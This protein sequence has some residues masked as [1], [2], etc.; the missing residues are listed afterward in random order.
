MSS[1][2]PRRFVTG[3]AD[4]LDEAQRRHQERCEMSQTPRRER[5]A[6]F[7]LDQYEADDERQHRKEVLQSQPV[8]HFGSHVVIAVDE[9]SYGP[10]KELLCEMLKGLFVDHE[11]ANLARDAAEERFTAH[12]GM[13]TPLKSVFEFRN[14]CKEKLNVETFAAC[15]SSLTKNIRIVTHQ[16]LSIQHRPLEPEDEKEDPDLN[17]KIGQIHTLL[18][19]GPSS[20]P[21]IEKF[22]KN[23]D[24]GGNDFLKAHH[25][26]LVVH[27]YLSPDAVFHPLGNFQRNLLTLAKAD[28]MFLDLIR[29]G[30]LLAVQIPLVP[31]NK[32]ATE[33]KTVLDSEEISDLF[34]RFT[35]AGIDTCFPQDPI[36]RRER[37]DP[38]ADEVNFPERF[39]ACLYVTQFPLVWKEWKR[40]QTAAKSSKADHRDDAERFR[41]MLKTLSAKVQKRQGKLVPTPP[42]FLEALQRNTGLFSLSVLFHKSCV[43][44]TY[45]DPLHV[46]DH[47]NFLEV[48]CACSNV[49]D[50]SVSAGIPPS[51]AIDSVLFV[52][53]RS[54]CISILDSP[55]RGNK[56][57][58]GTTETRRDT[59][60]AALYEEGRSI[61]SKRGYTHP[62]IVLLGDCPTGLAYTAETEKESSFTPLLHALGFVPK[63]LFNEYLEEEKKQQIRQAIKERYFDFTQNEDIRRKFLVVDQVARSYSIFAKFK[64]M[65]PKLLV[66]IDS[67]LLDMLSFCCPAQQIRFRREITAED[68]ERMQRQRAFS[69]FFELPDCE[70]RAN[71][72]VFL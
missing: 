62:A 31:P 43:A 11:L 24:V 38:W 23:A 8:T 58:S 7:H 39:Y 60:A 68:D 13:L 47:R 37:A 51:E 44:L 67:A 40:L 65:L 34:D 63:E 6:F 1:P 29:Q 5:N 35:C 52:V 18:C 41:E 4:F 2:T 64:P 61:L 36:E 69:S 48:C 16:Q 45:T 50:I 32:P 28:R 46:I 33:V 42:E 10:V 71:P 59:N 9:V 30:I 20:S 15:F 21:F 22:T 72:Q 17:I 56:K 55:A 14:Y 3:P 54:S 27:S 25:V 53:L 70:W 66:G 57:H 26:Q 49:S 19:F 12:E